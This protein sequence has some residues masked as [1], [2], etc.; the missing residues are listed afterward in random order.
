MEVD[1]REIAKMRLASLLR[2]D[3]SSIPRSSVVVEAT[4]TLHVEGTSQDLDFVLY[5]M[6]KPWS[7]DTATWSSLAKAAGPK[8]Q[9]A[10]GFRPSEKG[11]MK[12][13]VNPAGLAA[14]QAWIRDPRSNHG[15]LLTSGGGTD[16]AVFSTREHAEV[17]R[18]PKLTLLVGPGR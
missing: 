7:E 9:A 18:R 17:E 5:P 16:G 12:I 6:L 11:P 3:L 15:F 13:M 4:I 14:I 2:W 10:G 1:G 8:P